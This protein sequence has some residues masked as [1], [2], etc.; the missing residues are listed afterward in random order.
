MVQIGASLEMCS[1]CGKLKVCGEFWNVEPR[2]RAFW[3]ADCLEA[4]LAGVKAAA[5]RHPRQLVKQ[6]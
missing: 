2:F 3:C 6:E 5:M 4:M 1:D